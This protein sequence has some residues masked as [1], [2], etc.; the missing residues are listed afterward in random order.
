MNFLWYILSL[1]SLTSASAVVD[2][3]YARYEGRTLSNGVTQWL[4]IRYAAA[5][6]GNLRFAAPRD[7]PSVKGTQQATK[8]R[9]PC[10]H[11]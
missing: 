6:T 4:G 9:I 7:P 5:P 3:G 8:V 1:L 2:L 11:Q 10:A